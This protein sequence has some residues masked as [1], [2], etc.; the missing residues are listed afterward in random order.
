MEFRAEL[1]TRPG[2]P[3]AMQLRGVSRGVRRLELLASAD[4]VRLSG[5]TGSLGPEDIRQLCVVLRTAAKLHVGLR[6]GLPPPMLDVHGEPGGPG[7]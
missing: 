7:P 5:T 6:E 4:G 2:R 1:S 3:A